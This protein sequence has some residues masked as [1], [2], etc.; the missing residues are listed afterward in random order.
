MVVYCDGGGRHY[1]HAHGEE[2]EEIM[3]KAQ[4]A[5]N[6]TKEPF[7]FYLLAALIYLFLTV[8]IMAAMHWFERRANRGFVRTEL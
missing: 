5:A 7:T 6:A 1:L 8:F 4:T 2:F 3:R